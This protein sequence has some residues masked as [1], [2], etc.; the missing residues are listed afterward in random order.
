M[1]GVKVLKNDQVQVL[2]GKDAGKRGRVVR[3]WPRDAKVLVEGIN[4]VKRHERVRAATGRA[5]TQGGIITKEAP[6]H[7]SNVGVICGSCDRPVRVG[8]ETEDTGKRRVCKR[9]GGAL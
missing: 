8:Y 3:V 7:I 1:A 9:C 4:M 6:V 5:G 2:S